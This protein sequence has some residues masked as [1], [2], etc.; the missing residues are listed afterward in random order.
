[1]HLRFGAVPVLGGEGVDRQVTQAYSH[2]RLH[3]LAYGDDT[4]A[5][6]HAAIF[7]ARLRPSAV[8]IHDDGHMLWQSAVVNLFYQRHALFFNVSCQCFDNPINASIPFA[9]L[10][11]RLRGPKSHVR[12]SVVNTYQSWFFITLLPM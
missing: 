2:S 1:M 10:H 6:P 4:L 3:H 11:L 9:L 7:A 8:P 12:E 5:V